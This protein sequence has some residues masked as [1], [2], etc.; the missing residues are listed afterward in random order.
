MLLDTNILVYARN[1]GSPFFKK[2]KEVV[3]K[4]IKGELE[5]CISLQNL[6]EFYAVV[7]NPKRVQNPLTPQEAKKDVEE[8]LSYS[9][10]KKLSVKESTVRL[11]MELAEKYSISKQHIY[12]TQLVATM[13]ENGVKKI[14]TV[15]TNDFSVFSEIE[16]KNPFT[17]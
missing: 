5:A 15:N 1:S 2:A 8:Y 17:T 3:D 10:I 16:A 14:F 11:A 7:T 12:D 9:N 4:A 6:I 13:M